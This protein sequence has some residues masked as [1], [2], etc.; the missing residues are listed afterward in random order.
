M[1]QDLLSKSDDSL[2]VD[3]I[4]VLGEYPD[5]R[6]VVCHNVEALNSLKEKAAFLDRPNNRC[7]L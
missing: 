7:Q 1:I 3:L 5:E 6:P 4:Q 2:V